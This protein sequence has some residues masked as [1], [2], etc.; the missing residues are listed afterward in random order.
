MF[1]VIDAETKKAT[2]VN[3]A[4]ETIT[5]RTCQSLVEE[6][7]SYEEAI[8]PD[9]QA[10]VLAKLEQAAQNGYF[11]E[12]FRIVR[13]DGEVRWVWV[14]GF[15]RKDPNGKITRVGGTALDVTALKHAEDQVQANLAKANST[16]VEAEALRKATLALTED[17]HM[18]CVL[19][20]L[21]LSLAEL[22]PYT[23][24]RV[25]VPEGG[26]TGW[27]WAKN[28]VRNRPRSLLACL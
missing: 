18:D 11:E 12:R 5:G 6:P 10:H 17:L 16:W 24:A 20:A 3:P 28:H 23:C 19:D 1:W 21:L 7:S 15:P 22:V 14:R 27:R 9:D 4:Y 13:P 8:H 25:L 26:P 2:Y